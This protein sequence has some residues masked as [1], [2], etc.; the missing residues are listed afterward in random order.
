MNISG[1]GFDSSLHKYYD[2]LKYKN[3]GTG[4]VSSSGNNTSNR[5]D[6]NITAVEGLSE[7]NGFEAKLKRAMEQKDEKALREAC[8]SMEELFLNMMY[9]QMRAT[10]YKSDLIPD[11]MSNDIIQSMF[12][13]AMIKEATKSRSMGIADMLYKQLYKQMSNVYK[14]EGTEE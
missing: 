12:D 7:D 8:L 10:V 5:K 9:K 2:L 13:E 11:S 6:S 4:T 14:K 3:T 1:S